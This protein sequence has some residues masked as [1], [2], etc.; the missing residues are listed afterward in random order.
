MATDNNT[1]MATIDTIDKL[2][3]A[4]VDF[5]EHVK[6]VDV[7]KEEEEQ[8][9][10]EIIELVNKEMNEITNVIN[11]RIDNFKNNL[12][13]DNYNTICLFICN[14]DDNGTSKY[15]KHTARRII[16]KKLRPKFKK[17]EYVLHD[18]ADNEVFFD[19]PADGT[20]AEEYFITL[21]EEPKDI[22]LRKGVPT[23]E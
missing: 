17:F 19:V 18:E 10:K 21:R 4:T 11:S 9:E 22:V 16:T 23:L 8:C 5:P 3:K 14:N 2:M 7:T 12:T 1:T 20:I 15:I 6:D 13:N